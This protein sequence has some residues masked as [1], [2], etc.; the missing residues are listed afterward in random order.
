MGEMWKCSKKL[1]CDVSLSEAAISWVC[2]CCRSFSISPHWNTHTHTH[3]ISLPLRQH[4]RWTFNLPLTFFLLVCRSVGGEN[5]PKVAPRKPWSTFTAISWTRA[6][7]YL[8]HKQR[9]DTD[10]SKCGG[11]V[12]LLHLWGLYLLDLHDVAVLVEPSDDG[13]VYEWL[14]FWRSGVKTGISSL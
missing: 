10:R 5:R 9:V 3:R 4:R 1:S 6:M 12:E 14:W 11:A 7:K 13:Q 8:T 2:S